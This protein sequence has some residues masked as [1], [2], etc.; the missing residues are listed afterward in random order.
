M[1]QVRAQQYDTLDAICHRAYGRTAGVVE[2]TLAL[3]ANRG[4][5]EQ[6]PVLAQG[7]LVVL[8][9]IAAE[10]VREIVQLWS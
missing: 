9:D 10:A 1:P 8:P 3:D 4:L 6:G 5:A 7:T 2:Q